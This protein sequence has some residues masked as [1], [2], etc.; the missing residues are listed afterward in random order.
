MNDILKRKE[1]IIE[2]QVNYFVLKHSQ[3]HFQLF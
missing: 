1:Q 2:I 3:I